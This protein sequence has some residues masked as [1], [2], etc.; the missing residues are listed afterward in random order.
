MHFQ[1][2][3]SIILISLLSISSPMEITGSLICDDPHIKDYDLLI[4]LFKIQL[5]VD[6]RGKVLKNT[7]LS[8]ELILQ[9]LHWMKQIATIETL[10]CQVTRQITWQILRTLE[11]CIFAIDHKM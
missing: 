6:E 4:Q 2:L 8:K 11:S 5:L 1:L 10:N 7:L 3:S 9:I